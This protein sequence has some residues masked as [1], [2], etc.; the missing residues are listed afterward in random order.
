M[1]RFTHVLF[2]GVC[3]CVCVCVCDFLKSWT[4]L[5]LAAKNGHVS[6]VRLLIDAR[7]ELDALDNSGQTA[8]MLAALDGHAKVVHLLAKVCYF[9][10][11]RFNV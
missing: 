8:V 9:S 11:L 7:A 5:H 2:L 6:V 4:P 3:V 1:A 10:L